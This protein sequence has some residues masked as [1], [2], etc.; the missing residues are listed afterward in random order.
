ME[1]SYLDVVNFV[2]AANELAELRLPIRYALRVAQALRLAR[3]FYEDFDS[4]RRGVI[5]EC[6]IVLGDKLT[7]EEIER[8]EKAIPIANQKI[9]EAMAEK[10]KVDFEPI[11]LSDI[12]VQISVGL[13]DKTWW[14]WA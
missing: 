3:G 2:S 1:I 9:N 4:I 6:G 5:E 8:N 12:D 13:I 11:S 10:V 14:L 7:K